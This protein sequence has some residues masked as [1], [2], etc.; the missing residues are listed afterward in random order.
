MRDVV[1]RYARWGQANRA[2]LTDGRGHRGVTCGA[3]R[4]DAEFIVSVVGQ[5]GQGAGC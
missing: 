4:P 2:K 5:T 1:C 3:D